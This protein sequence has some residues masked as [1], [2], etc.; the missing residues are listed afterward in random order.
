MVLVHSHDVIARGVVVGEDGYRG[1]AGRDDRLL[2]VPG[3]YECAVRKA[4]AE[5]I[6][7]Q[8]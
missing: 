4:T 5:S 6:R 2:G 8:I 3:R 7:T 1:L